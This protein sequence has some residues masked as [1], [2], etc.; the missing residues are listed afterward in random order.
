MKQYSSK[1]E[2]ALREILTNPTRKGHVGVGF[3]NKLK[4]LE[5]QKY[6]EKIQS[7][8]TAIVSRFKVWGSAYLRRKENIKKAQEE[9]QEKNFI[10]ISRD[11]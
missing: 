6:E 3:T 4:K 9:E 2:R 8:N 10:E 11:S 1:Y 5:F 7:Y